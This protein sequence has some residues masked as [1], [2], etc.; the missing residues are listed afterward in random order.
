MSNLVI[1]YEIILFLIL[2][3][4][5]IIINI[6][7]IEK[8]NNQILKTSNTIKKILKLNSNTNFMIQDY[9]SIVFKKRTKTLALFRNIKPNTVVLHNIEHNVNRLKFNI[10]TMIINLHK[11][12]D[13]INEFNTIECEIESSVLSE[14]K[15]SLKKYIK[16]EKRVKEKIKL[17]DIFSIT[18][19]V[20]GLY[21]SPKGRN[22]YEQKW[23]YAANDLVEIYDLYLNHTKQKNQIQ[24]ERLKMSTGL[25]YD[26]LKRDNFK[27]VICGMS[28]QDGVKL[29]VDHI[30]PVSKGGKSEVNNLQTLCERCNLGKSNKI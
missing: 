21:C 15:Y 25:R 1:S 17:N 6:L 2:I 12:N 19:T 22:C 3:F 27:C 11:Y 23:V 18:L 20:V 14:T 4:S 7:V 8:Q 26:I 29:H 28:A 24:M 13:Y 16:I 30:V 5:I 9:N 10:E